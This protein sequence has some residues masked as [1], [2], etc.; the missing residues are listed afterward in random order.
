MMYRSLWSCIG[1]YGDVPG[2]MVMY[3]VLMIMYEGVW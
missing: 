2:C 3:R 1:V